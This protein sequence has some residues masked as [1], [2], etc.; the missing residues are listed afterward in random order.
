MR[1]LALASVLAVCAALGLTT[2][3]TAD[4]RIILT[5]SSTLA[6][7]MLEVAKRYETVHPDV[8]VDVQTGGSSR[9]I[10]DAR[11]GTADIGMVSRTLYDSEADLTA[12]TVARDGICL[13]VH[14]DNPVEAITDAEVAAIYRGATSD[15]SALGGPGGEITVVN[16]AA[17]RAT[18]AVFLDYLGLEAS[19][20]EADLIVG[21]N[22]QGIK[23]V[24]GNRNAIGYVS[25]GAARENADLGVPIR[26]LALGGAPAT[27]AAVAD[28][29]YQATRE[30][31]LVT[32]S[33]QPP[34]RIQR[35][36]DYTRSQAV[37]DI[38]RDLHYVPI[39]R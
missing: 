3:A 18:L 1:A 35:F 8:R 37:H 20:I 36:I 38:I 9:G 13:I 15:W 26:L 32:P 16:K 23:V 5:G 31:N 39:Q 25:I 29:R 2:P 10:T 7:M 30:L 34:A 28:G 6:P 11:S 22:E 21:H 17:G 12:H 19:D 27:A 14:A 33:S 4:Q 24:A